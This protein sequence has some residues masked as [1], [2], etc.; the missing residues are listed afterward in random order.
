MMMVSSFNQPSTGQVKIVATPARPEASDADRRDRERHRL[1]LHRPGSA[2]RR[3][4]CGPSRAEGQAAG[5]AAE[6]LGLRPLRRAAEA[7]LHRPPHH[8]R[9]PRH[10]DPQP[11]AAHRRRLQAATSSS[12]TTSPAR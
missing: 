7:R 11:A 1:D 8:P 5:F 10:R 6:A 4:R 12:P 3:G 2:R 9:L